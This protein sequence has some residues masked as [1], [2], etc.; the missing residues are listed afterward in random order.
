MKDTDH[1]LSHSRRHIGDRASARG[2][3][4][5]AWHDDQFGRGQN[6]VLG[7]S[8]PTFGHRSVPKVNHG[9][10]QPTGL[11]SMFCPPAPPDSG[12]N[13]QRMKLTRVKEVK[14]A[15]CTFITAN[16][17]TRSSACG[18]GSQAFA[19][20]AS[21]KVAAQKRSNRGFAPTRIAKLRWA[22]PRICQTTCLTFCTNKKGEASCPF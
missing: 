15:V 20:T 21:A 7:W 10:L 11:F 2:T 16:F 14:I 17:F 13:G 22:A 9:S 1:H 6:T 3:R 5:C 19:T 4:G 18:I 12:G 8:D